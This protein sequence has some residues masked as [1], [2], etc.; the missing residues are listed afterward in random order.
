MVFYFSIPCF[1]KNIYNEQHLSLQLFILLCFLLLNV[2]VDVSMLKQW[3]SE[4]KQI[5][6]GYYHTSG[7]LTGSSC[8]K[9][10]HTNMGLHTP[11]TFYSLYAIILPHYC[12]VCKYNCDF[13]FY[14]P[15]FLYG[16]YCVSFSTGVR[17][18]AYISLPYSNLLYRALAT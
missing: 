5:E 10:S 9:I 16:K 4:L 6:K 3:D 18:F 15:K 1:D 11:K 14:F 7:Y 17:M 8:L 13:L 12:K 2:Y